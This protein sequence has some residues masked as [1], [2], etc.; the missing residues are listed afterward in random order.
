M[1]VPEEMESGPHPSDCRQEFRVTMTII[2]D[3][4]WWTVGDK[5]VDPVWHLSPVPQTF[6]FIAESERSTV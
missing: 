2:E 4:C 3:S 1:S 5:D 6:G